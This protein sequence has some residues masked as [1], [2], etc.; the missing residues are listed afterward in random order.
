MDGT[1]AN[2]LFCPPAG[3]TP[4]PRPTPVPV[5]RRPS[6]RF[7]GWHFV[8]ILL[9]IA[10]LLAAGLKVHQ[11]ATTPAVTPGL[12]G[13][14]WLALAITEIE[15]VLG[16]LLLFNMVRR[17]FWF[18]CILFFSAAAAVSLSKALAGTSS[19][20]CF[21]QL[22]INPWMSFA[23][24]LVAITLLV[25]VRPSPVGSHRHRTPAIY[26]AGVLVL[27]API[28]LPLLVSESIEVLEPQ[29]W[30]GQELPILADIKIDAS[31]TTGHWIV[32]LVHHDCGRCRERINELSGLQSRL[33]IIQVPPYGEMSAGHRAAVGSLRNGTEWFVETPT[34]LSLQDGFV[35]G[36]SQ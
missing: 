22:Q 3:M 19:C 10:L 16:L 8:R 24:D 21:G 5:E 36:V 2:S 4:A 7:V 14:R 35:M 31:L 25:A 13:N 23:F 1:R 9:G 17:P 32:L 34:V 26:L 27:A 28:A 15:L 29:S 6:P 12:V 20:G 33:A 30:V 18:A 11:F